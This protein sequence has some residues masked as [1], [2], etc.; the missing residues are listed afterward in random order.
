MDGPFS[1]DLSPVPIRFATQDSIPDSAMGLFR[2]SSRILDLRVERDHQRTV[3]G[4]TVD[5]PQVLSRLPDPAASKP[6]VDM[7]ARGIL[8][9]C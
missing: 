2:V 7:A 4:P 9:P 1:Q 3:F 5:I 6:P 8:F